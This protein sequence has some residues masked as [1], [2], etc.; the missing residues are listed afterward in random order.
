VRCHH[1]YTGL[2]SLLGA[3]EPKPP[4]VA[5][6]KLSSEDF[7]RLQRARDAA[8]LLPA[9]RLVVAAGPRAPALA[10]T[11]TQLVRGP[12]GQLRA[13]PGLRLLGAGP[14]GLPA[15]PR[16]PGAGPQHRLL[17][18]PSQVAYII[19][20]LLSLKANCPQTGVRRLLTLTAAGP[21]PRLPPPP[22]HAPWPAPS[23]TVCLNMY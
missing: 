14:A 4:A 5:T 12:S 8:A 10:R 1:L 16:L 20:R 22:H 9:P 19:K 21:L 3:M 2:Q 13:P 18:V 23:G 6:L 11:A 15:V 17:S 7:Q